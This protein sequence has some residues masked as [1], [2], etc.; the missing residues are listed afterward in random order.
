MKLKVLL[1]AMALFCV[2]GIFA[3][4][5][6]SVPLENQIYFI[7]EQAQTRGLCAPL[8]GARPYTQETVISAIREV[9]SFQETKKLSNVEREILEQY[10]IKFSKPKKGIDWNRGAYYSE[11]VIDKNDTAFSANIGI[12]ADIEGSAG[13]YLKDKNYF[14]TD[15]WPG[16]Y[17]NGDLGANVSYEFSARGGLVIAPRKMLGDDYWTYYEGFSEEENSQYSNRQIE[18]YSEPLTHFPYTYKKRWDGS[19]Y[20]LAGDLASFKSWPV[21]T[22]GGYNLLSELTASFLENKF[23]IR[24]GRL[25]HD[26]GSSPLGSSLFFNQTA[27]PFLGIE[28]ELYPVSWLGISS[29]TGVLEYDNLHGLKNSSMVFQNAFSVT[30]L[31]FRYKNYLF[32]DF[33]D[34]VIWPKRFELGYISPITNSFFYQ[35]NIGDFDNMAISLTVKAQ[36]PGAGNI[37]ASIFIDE[38]N[39]TDDILTL[40]RQMFSWQTGLTASLP[41]LSFSSIKLSYTKI[42]P[43]CY[44]HNRNYNPWYGGDVPMETAYINNGVSLGYYLPPNSD[45]LLFS[46]STMPVKNLTANLQYQMIRHGAD[47]GSGAVDG[48]NLLSELDPWG[49]DTKSELKRYFLKDGAYQ[50]MHIIKLEGEWTLAASD[51][52]TP[53][54]VFC[55]TGTVISYF[56]NTKEKPNS[57]KAENYSVIDT[58]EYPKSTGLILKLGVKL[59]PR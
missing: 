47:F 23:L 3:Q 53:L 8:K 55:E 45:E 2:T 27:R 43:Y 26:W 59:Y 35:N 58:A 21:E 16:I 50:W 20:F 4:S 6:T 11:T 1:V 19:V 41:F 14:G 12:T 22:A 5:H 52:A 39:L 36:Y 46:F 10:L 51:K 32:V 54:A 9:L 7:L 13:I 38:M 28:S 25:Y 31:Q 57:G 15:I 44:T 18:T 49:R 56:T 37:W 33:A 34:S 48:S 29:L 40:D 30:M 42:N 24:F 17:M